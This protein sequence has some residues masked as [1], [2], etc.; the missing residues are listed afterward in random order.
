MSFARI[1]IA[2][3]K[4]AAVNKGGAFAPL[5]HAMTNSDSIHQHPP[6]GNHAGPLPVGACSSFDGAS[7]AKPATDLTP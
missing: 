7:V 1:R 6:P 3:P 5:I 4:G 2:W